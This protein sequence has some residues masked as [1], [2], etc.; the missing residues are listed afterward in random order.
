MNPHPARTLGFEE[1]YAGL[2]RSIA[3][4]DAYEKV[5]EDGLRL[6]CYSDQCTYERHWNP[7]TLL[8]RGLILDINSRSVIATP[9]PKF[10]NYGE[11]V[12][13]SVPMPDEP[14]QTFEKLDG[15][16]IIIFH[17]KG[18][19]KFATKGSFVSDQAKWAQRWVGEHY[20]QSL[21]YLHPG[22]TYLAE[23]IYPENRIVIDYGDMRGLVLLGGY[24]NDG[25]EYCHQKIIEL[26]ERIGWP[27]VVPIG[28]FEGISELLEKAGMLGGDAEGWVLRFENGLRLKIKGE[29][30]CRLHR[31][32]SNLTPLAI[33]RQM[34][35]KE[36][37]GAVRRAL[38]E[39]F[40]GDFDTIIR[41]LHE[42]LTEFLGNVVLFAQRTVG[43]TDK[44]VGLSLEQFPQDYR[45][46]IFPWRKNKG[47]LLEGRSR[48][49][50]F[51][52][53]RPDRNV[54]PGYR[55]SSSMQR[56]QE[57]MKE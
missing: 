48:R 31:M 55:A 11:A 28:G 30:Y 46:F 39:E 52:F 3:A 22:S 57:N 4:G 40:W 18:E 15:S 47:A 38:P 6:Y 13:A 41:L 54:L 5:G 35:D 33:W 23:V 37:L 26:G 9:F 36:D 17:H 53:I 12:G 56:V 2:Q 8:A 32:I 25:Y 50:V 42:Q 14:F 44:E 49:R 7:I 16:L 20:S 45:A 27:T 51:E 43:L 10:F 24:R 21:E 29:E 1:L 34:L 19:W